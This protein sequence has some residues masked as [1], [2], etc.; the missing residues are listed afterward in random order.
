MRALLLIVFVS[1][2]VRAERDE[3]ITADPP[4]TPVSKPPLTPEALAQRAEALHKQALAEPATSRRVALLDECAS[5]YPKYAPCHR[6]LGTAAYELGDFPKADRAWE[7][8]LV[9]SPNADDAADVR[10]LIGQR[11]PS[12]GVRAG[13]ITLRDGAENA[14]SAR[15]AGAVI[16]EAAAM[17]KAGESPKAV[18]L[19]EGYLPKI[20]SETTKLD[21]ARLWC[22]LGLAHEASNNVEKARE[23]FLVGA[24]QSPSYPDCHYFL[25]RVGDSAEPCKTYLTLAPNGQFEK[26]ARRRLIGR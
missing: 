20:P 8:Y 6:D 17:R 22:E 2:C 5:Y 25:C 26:D 10:E 18:R 7:R 9:V 11:V 13:A 12:P 14:G 19:L 16:S 4:K 3:I 24:E 15:A 1:A 23:S 21:E